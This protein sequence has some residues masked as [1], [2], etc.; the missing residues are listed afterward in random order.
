MY[1]TIVFMLWINNMFQHRIKRI[2]DCIQF[3][4]P[5]TVAQQYGR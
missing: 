2:V 3:A 1:L 4:R 5:M